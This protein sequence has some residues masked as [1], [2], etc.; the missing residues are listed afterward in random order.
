MNTLRSLFSDSCNDIYRIRFRNLPCFVYCSLLRPNGKEFK[1]SGDSVPLLFTR[2]VTSLSTN[3]I[4]RPY[5][6]SSA[7]NVYMKPC[8]RSISGTAKACGRPFV[9]SDLGISALYLQDEHQPTFQ[10]SQP[11]R[12]DVFESC[13]ST[14]HKSRLF[15]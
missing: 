15:Q 4:F 7:N 2:R 6:S 9:K 12:R 10:E 11:E 13:L 14:F 3:S 5:K 8:P 1:L